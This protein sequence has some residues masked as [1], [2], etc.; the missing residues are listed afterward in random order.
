MEKESFN[1]RE[2]PGQKLETR[3]GMGV[4]ELKMVENKKD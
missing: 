3:K 4:G 1:S 2:W